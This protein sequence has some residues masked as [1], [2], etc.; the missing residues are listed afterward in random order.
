M[1]I[2]SAD[3]SRA[4]MCAMLATTC[5]VA[6]PCEVAVACCVSNGACGE[7]C[8]ALHTRA[9]DRSGTEWLCALQDLPRVI[10]K[11]DRRL[12]IVVLEAS[13]WTKLS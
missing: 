2:N 7:V 9:A 6:Q 4:L 3:A 5:A 12:E 13:V 8:G 11:G 1:A 10:R